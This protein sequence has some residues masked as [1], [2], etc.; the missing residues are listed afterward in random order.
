M[1][2]ELTGWLEVMQDR[3]LDQDDNRGLQQPVR[4]NKLTP[5]RFRIL[6]EG[7]QSDKVLYFYRAYMI[8]TVRQGTIFLSDVYDRAKLFQ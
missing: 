4:D 1:L 5:N 3:R 7:R 8:E 2:V 6:V